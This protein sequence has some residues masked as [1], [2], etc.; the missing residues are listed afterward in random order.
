[1]LRLMAL[2]APAV[3]TP[4]ERC[5]NWQTNGVP[6]LVQRMAIEV[7]RSAV[8]ALRRRPSLDEQ[9]LG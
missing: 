4:P 1:M 6:V 5:S 9:D 8:L 2:A 7:D 3:H